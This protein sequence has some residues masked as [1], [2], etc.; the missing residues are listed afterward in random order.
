MHDRPRA[1]VKDP[2]AQRVLARS[3][4]HSASFAESDTVHLASFIFE[5]RRELQ[6]ANYGG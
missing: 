2:Q 4:H 3:G 1:R 5:Y 6:A